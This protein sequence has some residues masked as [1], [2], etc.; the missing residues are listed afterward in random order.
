MD[1]LDTR[2]AEW[3]ASGDTGTSSK[4]I[5]LWLWRKRVDATWGPDIPRDTGDLAR[6]LRLLERIP[7]WKPRMPEMAEA[8]G[9]WP[10][11]SKHW[12][13]IVASFMDECGG[14]IPAPYGEWP[15]FDKTY[16]LM[17]KA[18]DAALKADNPGFQ[19]ISFSA[20]KLAGCSVRFASGSKYADA[21]KKAGKSRRRHGP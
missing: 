19:E 3:F 14:V 17:L 13:R 2:L 8:G 11:F 5:A 20:G 16:A 7:E 4:A 12:G 1:D 21:F 18:N 9:L 15:N 6:C 10:T